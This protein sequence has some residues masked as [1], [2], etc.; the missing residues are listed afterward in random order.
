VIHA[1]EARA[2]LILQ[3]HVAHYRSCRNQ[4]QGR[5]TPRLS[6]PGSG[7]IDR[8]T[9]LPGSLRSAVAGADQVSVE[10]DKVGES[11]G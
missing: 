6:T 1:H 10:A 7:T 11:G 8:H 9:E 4:M 5:S 3:R 2:P